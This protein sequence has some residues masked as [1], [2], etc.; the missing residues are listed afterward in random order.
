MMKY[1][2]SF[3]TVAVFYNSVVRMGGAWRAF[4]LFWY[5]RRKTGFGAIKLILSIRI[6]LIYIDLPS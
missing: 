5:R 4:L 1:L 3:I 6:L 2:I